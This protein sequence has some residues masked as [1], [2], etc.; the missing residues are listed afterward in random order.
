[1]RPKEKG[2]TTKG[3]IVMTPL[4]AVPRQPTGSVILFTLVVLVLLG[5]MGFSLMVNTR[6]ELSISKNTFLGR[7]AFSKA[8]LT[9]R[10]ALFAGRILLNEGAGEPCDILSNLGTSPAG[11][12]VYEV[13]L[14][15]TVV[16]SA[17]GGSTDLTL[18]SITQADEMPTLQ[19][20][21]DRYLQ[22][23]ASAHVPSSSFT[24][25]PQVSVLFGGQVVGTAALVLY[26]NVGE[27][28]G[29]LEDSGYGSQGENS[30]RAY[31]VVSANGR[32][33][34]AAGEDAANYYGRENPATHSI[35]TAVYREIIVN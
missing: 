20:I 26:Y 21:L 9:T 17:A 25:Q 4:P 31:L 16:C 29:S 18:E 33:P 30:L 13:R 10:L 3:E 1:M 23:T 2:R 19:D 32:L 7:D 14:G 5:L 27:P 6:T 35:I 8:D 11:R 34:Q 22:A 28:G 24:V 15:S 12:P